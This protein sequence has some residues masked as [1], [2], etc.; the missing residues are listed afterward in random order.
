MTDLDA[1]QAIIDARLADLRRLPHFPGKVVQQHADLTVDVQPD[2]P[3]LPGLTALQLRV[4]FPGATV[5]VA[6]GSRVAVVFEDGDTKRPVAVPLFER[7]AGGLVELDVGDAGTNINLAAGT[8]GAARVG[9]ACNFALTAGP[10]TVVG[11]I[12]IGQ[13]SAKVKVG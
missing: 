10:Y 7:D 11:S 6:A 3:Y 13:G 4:P 2:S 1:L 5:K 12:T 9:D 8:Q